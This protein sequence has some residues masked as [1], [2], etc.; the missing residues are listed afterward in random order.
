MCVY[1]LTYIH[2]HKTTTSRK[3]SL[4][5][6][7]S[8]IRSNERYGVDIPYQ[9]SNLYCTHALSKT[10]STLPY[11]IYT[12]AFKLNHGLG[13]KYAVLVLIWTAMSSGPWNS[14][15]WQDGRRQILYSRKEKR[16]SVKEDK[17][18]R[19]STYVL[20]GHSLTNGGSITVVIDNSTDTSAPSA[21]VLV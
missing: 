18:P 9:Y 11:L 10:Q 2:T 16:D 3:E 4:D 1:T 5:R 8:E 19:Y 6:S 21:M 12:T 14:Q 7:R 17:Y 20:G 13:R 15:M